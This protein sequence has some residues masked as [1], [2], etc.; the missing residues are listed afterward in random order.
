MFGWLILL[1]LFLG[2]IGNELIHYT[3]GRCVYWNSFF[4]DDSLMHFRTWRNYVSDCVIYIEFHWTLSSSVCF[5]IESSWKDRQ[6]FPIVN[7]DADKKTDC[8]GCRTHWTAP[9]RIEGIWRFEKNPSTVKHL[10]L[11]RGWTLDSCLQKRPREE[12]EWFLG[13]G[14]R[15]ERKGSP[16][17]F[18]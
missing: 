7:L 17:Q 11:L 2:L 1:T 13:P 15:L 5:L 8:A 3:L 6:I 14:E 9:K 4:V 18:Y 10:S 16:G 12:D